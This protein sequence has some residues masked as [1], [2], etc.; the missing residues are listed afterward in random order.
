[1]KLTILIA[2]LTTGFALEVEAADKA[3]NSTPTTLETS[4]NEMRRNNLSLE[5]LGRGGLYSFNY[6][7]MLNDDLA[8]GGGIASYSISAGTAKASTWILPV[9]ANY[10]VNQGK[11]RFFGTGGA[12]LI[13]VSGQID[14]SNQVKGSG[15]A[16]VLGA[17]YEYKSDDGFLFRAAPYLM[18]GKISGGWLGFSLGYSI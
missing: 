11:H 8:V 12:N 7:Y 2:L 13:L 4:S 10:Y 18:I 17:G 1:M 9:Y 6:D 15:L 3:P 5:L 14:D 16:G